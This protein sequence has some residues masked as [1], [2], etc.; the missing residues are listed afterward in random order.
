M[1]ILRLSITHSS[2]ER[3]TLPVLIAGPQPL[4]LYANTFDAPSLA[5]HLIPLIHQYGPESTAV[6]AP[7]VRQSRPVQ[8]LVNYLSEKHGLLVAEPQSDDGPLDE[9]VLRDKICVSTYHQFKGNERDLVITYGVDASYFIH[10]AKDL[11]DDICPNATFVALTRAHKQLVVINDSRQDPMPFVDVFELENTTNII[12]L[13]NDE[14]IVLESGKSGRP[15]QLG[16]QLPAS[17]A[18]SELPRHIPD[19]IVEEICTK[20]LRIDQILPPLSKALHLDAPAIVLTDPVKKHYEA[21]SDLNGLAVVA[22]YEYA[23]LGTLTTLGKTRW[24]FP[25]LFSSTKAQ[26]IWLCRESCAYSARVSGYKPRKLQM[27]NHA[28]DWLASYLDAARFRLEAQFVEPAPL[29]FEVFLQGEKFAVTDFLGDK[30][31]TIKVNG[32]ADI[33]RYEGSLSTTSARNPKAKKKSRKELMKDIKFEEVSIWEIKFVSQLS[34][35][36]VIQV[37]V[38]AYLWCN[39]H[40]RELPPRIYLFNV[41]NGEKWEIVPRKGIASLRAVVEEALIAKYTSPDVLSTDEFLKQCKK[42]V[43]EVEKKFRITDV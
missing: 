6:L 14:E 12:N 28:F 9:N 20:H 8:I 13:D 3:N 39:T 27:K 15:M 37:C 11:P 35:E 16:L 19:H 25:K 38:Y 24:L 43:D 17:V 5:Q 7:S 42:T 1:K 21:V 10:Q 30:R 26:A 33:I 23:L 41:R 2:V 34:L 40:E 32:R 22:A 18:A 29:D 31:Q 4:Y 36:H